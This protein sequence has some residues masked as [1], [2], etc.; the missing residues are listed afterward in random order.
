MDTFTVVALGIIFDPSKRK[1][2]L[3]RRENDPDVP[4]L[5][6]SFPSGRISSEDDVDKKLK[7]RIK[8]KTGYAVKNLGAVFARIFP[9]NKKIFQVY[10]LVEAFEGEEKAGGDLVELKWVSPDEIQDYF[11]TPFHSVLKEYITNLK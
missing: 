2:L 3:G 6:W 5:T 8:E 9:D 7:Q 11:S 1:I 10:F 4:G